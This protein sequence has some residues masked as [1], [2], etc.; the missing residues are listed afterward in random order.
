MIKYAHTHTD[1]QSSMYFGERTHLSSILRAKGTTLDS[2][3]GY[4]LNLGDY[5][6]ST[7]STS[8]SFLQMKKAPTSRDSQP[9]NLNSVLTSSCH[10]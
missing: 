8:Y 9:K 2:D 3:S 7:S 10:S 6:D 4:I 1:T 5:S